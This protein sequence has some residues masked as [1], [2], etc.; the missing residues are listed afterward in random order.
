M[1]RKIIDSH[2]HIF[3][4]DVK[5]SFPNQNVSHGFPEPHQKEIFRTHSIDEAVSEMTQSNVGGAVFVQCYSDCP[6]EVEW[7]YSQAAAHPSVLGVVGGLDLVQHEKMKASIEKFLKFPRPKFVGVR[8]LIS[9]EDEEYLRREDVHQGLQI[10]SDHGLTFDLQS[11]PNTIKHIP[12]IAEK[13]PK[14][15]M[16]IDHIAKPNY[17]ENGFAGW[18]ADMSALAKYKNVHCKLSGMVNEVPFWSTDS[19]RPYVQHCLDVFGVSRVMFG[20]D[21]P[22]CKV[23]QPQCD[24]RNTLNLLLAL[25]DHL[26][27]EDVNKIFYQNAVTF[28]GLQHLV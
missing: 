20:S 2:F 15:K 11:Y 4:L 17:L 21:W 5:K 3:D 10:L 24:Y 1:I 9:F 7:V 14:L 25:T 13:F 12:L 19:F 28:Y 8:H 26:T 6:E 16:V 18:A 23:S 22:V 27:A